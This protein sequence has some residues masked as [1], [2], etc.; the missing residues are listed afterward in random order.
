M[1]APVLN[2]LCTTLYKYLYIAH[3]NKYKNKI[4]W[5]YK[6]LCDMSPLNTD[7]HTHS[8]S[9]FFKAF[10]TVAR[11]QQGYKKEKTNKLSFLR[12]I[13]SQLSRYNRCFSQFLYSGTK[14]SI[15]SN[16]CPA[17]LAILQFFCFL[18]LKLSTKLRILVD[19]RKEDMSKCQYFGSLF[20]R[21]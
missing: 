11:L 8:H 5:T 17:I 19:N 6:I 13:I 4:F 20:N 3:I 1:A 15:L 9:L 10:I 21:D 7:Y 18:F 12:K 14:L 16:F 2:M